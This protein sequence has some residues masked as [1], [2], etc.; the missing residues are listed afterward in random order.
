[1]TEEKQM[2]K[3]DAGKVANAR[4]ASGLLRGRRMVKNLR[5]RIFE[6]PEPHTPLERGDKTKKWGAPAR[7][8]HTRNRVF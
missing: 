8:T 3:V 1:V 6:T 2:V 5:E 4:E 7:W